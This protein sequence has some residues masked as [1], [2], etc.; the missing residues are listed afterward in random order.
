MG[1]IG[2][3]MYGGPRVSNAV[4]M[5]IMGGS[6]RSHRQLFPV[7]CFHIKDLTTCT[8]MSI[9]PPVEP[10]HLLHFA[11]P[12]KIS[13]PFRIDDDGIVNM[14]CWNQNA[15]CASNKAAGWGISNNR[16]YPRS[17]PSP[18]VAPVPLKKHDIMQTDAGPVPKLLFIPAREPSCVHP[19][20]A[21]TSL[22]SRFLILHNSKL[23]TTT[24][25]RQ[26]SILRERNPCLQPCSRNRHLLKE[27]AYV[28]TNR[29]VIFIGFF[30]GRILHIISK[31]S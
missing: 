14:F 29:F 18:S 15:P 27:I 9:H 31:V 7:S 11:R 5:D 17:H 20:R 25:Q 6:Q 10:V 8:S 13:S 28:P 12:Q 23:Q 19:P 22:S 1:K 26:F 3:C 4:A 2:S 21:H 30:L 24:L 16:V